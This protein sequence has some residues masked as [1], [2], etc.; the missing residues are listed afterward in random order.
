MSNVGYLKILSLRTSSR[1]A[2]SVICLFEGPMNQAIFFA[3][4]ALKS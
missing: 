3:N 2:T 4:S 1:P